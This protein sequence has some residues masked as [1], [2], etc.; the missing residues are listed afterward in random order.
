V[1][2]AKLYAEEDEKTRRRVEAGPAMSST[3][4]AT[5]STAV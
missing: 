5:S 4:P 2:E 3:M 1:E